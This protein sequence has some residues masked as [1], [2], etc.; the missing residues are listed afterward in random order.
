MIKEESNYRKLLL[1]EMLW[2]E[3][4]EIWK[5]PKLIN[6]FDPWDELFKR[7]DQIKKEL[8]E[9]N[10]TSGYA[11]IDSNSSEINLFIRNTTTQPVEIKNIKV[12]EKV[13]N[14]D[15]IMIL[16]SDKSYFQGRE[17]TFVLPPLMDQ[18]AI[19]P[20]FIRLSVGKSEL[21]KPKIIEVEC[22]LWGLE[23]GTVTNTYTVEL[24]SFDSDL[25]PLSSPELQ[26]DE[27][28][29]N[30]LN[31]KITIE[32]GNYSVEKNIYIPS[33]FIVYIDKG[34]TLNFFK[35]TTFVSESPIQ[36]M[37]TEEKNIELKSFSGD[38]SG[39]LLF[40]TTSYSKFKWINISDVSGVGK[41]S[42][43]NGHE[44]N[45][46]NMT[47]G[48]TAY[49][50]PIEFEN[51]HFKNLQTEDAL[52]IISSTFTLNKCTFVNSYSDAFDGDFVT[53]NFKRMCI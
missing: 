22:R 48:I 6:N 31:N 24:L 14:H 33:G 18:Q 39:V 38:W 45:G 10:L 53:G 2:E 36:A 15:E 21:N 19:K 26:L 50:S 16:N 41:A 51:C 43:P 37:G 52:N 11:N 12:G 8:L 20:K 34:T 25:L 1:A 47:G 17:K 44:F 27:V 29:F 7:A 3:P 23:K 13:L 28:D 40:N 5:D 49:K 4:I 9:N 42:N 46:W 32:E 35:G 30:I